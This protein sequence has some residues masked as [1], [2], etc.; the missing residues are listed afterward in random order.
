MVM[1]KEELEA[2][3]RNNTNAECCRQL[4]VS[5]ATLLAHIRNAGIELKGKGGGFASAKIKVIKHG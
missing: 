1:T 4:G 3:Y 2:L 5:K